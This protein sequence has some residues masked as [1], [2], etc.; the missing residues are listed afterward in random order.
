MIS[1]K[2]EVYEISDNPAK[3][4]FN[5]YFLLIGWFTDSLDYKLFLSF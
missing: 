2:V 1:D 3:Y 5:P 4:A